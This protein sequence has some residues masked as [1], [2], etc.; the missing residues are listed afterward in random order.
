MIIMLNMIIS[1]LGDV[2]DEF[3]LNAEI[4]NFNEM[5]LVILENEQILSSFIGTTENLKYLHVCVHAYES[6]GSDW[7]GKVIDIRDFLK[8]KFLNNDLR[9]ILNE[10]K[11]EIREEIKAIDNKIQAISE[12]AKA[13]NANIQDRIQG[14]EN[15]I[16]NIQESIDII[17]KILSK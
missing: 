9:P 4:Y 15:K 6:S 13:N 7:K 2:F 10:N 5:A 1:I 16:S 8:D 12:E 11:K 14:V 3:Q 17:L